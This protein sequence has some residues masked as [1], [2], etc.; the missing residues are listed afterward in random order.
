MKWSINYIKVI[1]E[2]KIK[3]KVNTRTQ[4]LLMGVVQIKENLLM[5]HLTMKEYILM[6]AHNSMLVT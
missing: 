1:A 3:R 4:S 6:V 2:N 5:D